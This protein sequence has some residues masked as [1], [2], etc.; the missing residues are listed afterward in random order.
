M[1]RKPVEYMSAVPEGEIE[2]DLGPRRDLDR[3]NPD[4]LPFHAIA[5]VMN[6]NYEEEFFTLRIVQGSQEE[7]D[8]VPFPPIW[9]GAGKRHFLGAMPEV[10]DFCV[11]GW[12][13]QES[14]EGKWG[15]KT[16]V[17]VGWITP[18]TWPGRDWL[19]T[20]PFSED[21]YDFSSVKNRQ[22]VRGAFNRVR[23]KLRHK[24]PGNIVAYSSQGSDLVLDESVTL[25][26]RRGNEL[27]LRDSDQ[28]IVM[29][30]LQQF[31]ATAGGRTYHGM[32][33]RDAGFLQPTMF[34]DGNL[35]DGRTQSEQGEPVHEVE[36]PPAP[37]PEDFL[38]PARMLARKLRED[39]SG[40]G[41]SALNPPSRIDPYNFLA[42]GGYIDAKGYALTSDRESDTYYGGKPYFRVASGSRANAAADPDVPTLTEFRLELDHTSRGRLP[43][44]EQTDG[45]D[46]ER[47]PRSGVGT[48]D[49]Q[50]RSG[51]RYMDLVYGSVV[52]NDR[53]SEYGRQRYG[54]P[55][56]ANVFTGDSASPR[57]DP[58]VIAAN[59]DAGVV[60]TPIE[61]HLATLFR[62]TPQ[63]SQGAPDTFWGV[64]KKGQLK[65][66]LSGPRDEDSVQ[67]NI[68]GGLRLNVEGQVS[69]GFTQGLKFSSKQG[70]NDRNIGVEFES[71]RGAVRI[72][73]GGSKRGV[74]ALGERLSG[75]GNGEGDLPSVEIVAGTSALVKAQ[76]KATLKGDQAE[77][78]ARSVNV[79]GHQ[80][81]TLQ[82][83]DRIGVDTKAMDVNIVGKRTMTFAGPKDLLPTSGALDEK[84]YAT[85]PG[86][87]AKRTLIAF[88]D[89]SDEI[90]LGN[91]LN[92]IRV[93]NMLHTVNVGT[94]SMTS[95]L[96]NMTLTPAT[97]TGA[98]TGAIAFESSGGAAVLSGTANATLVA[99]AGPAVVRGTS[100][101]I[102]SAPADFN[103]GPIICAGSLDPLT[104]LPFLT[105]G[106]GAKLHLVT[107]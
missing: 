7:F 27:I 54:L 81:I 99:K 70:D 55:L 62:M 16:P 18:G 42:Q 43:V 29:R 100:G 28:A 95:G 101:V 88:G 22:A 77:V 105:W 14:Q 40:L 78:N 33:Q 31:H 86:L 51:R 48:N 91:H 6:I 20:S 32:V 76:R 84:T 106:M 30:S 60:P 52:G 82:A 56:V 102:L 44:T 75:T 103:Q 46:A 36:L 41:K 45:F 59:E 72:F 34:S 35:W 61:E 25:A 24:Q 4:H 85:I 49:P 8:R 67:A 93:G 90:L 89:R 92:T 83:A 47:I 19:T 26:N 80:E 9:P 97:I 38:T 104:G 74:D 57:I 58:A 87:N 2:R 21:E 1:T 71:E 15:T 10:G 107:V 3:M 5:K 73:G 23:H 63:T 79:R 53:F 12:M 65:A 64:N 50:G 98:T 39:G 13:V 37:E 69:L 17:I 94:I 96:T 68:R 66:S 11:V